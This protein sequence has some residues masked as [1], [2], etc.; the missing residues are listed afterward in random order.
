VNGP[1]P[2]SV[3]FLNHTMS[4]GGGQR[5]VV[6]QVRAVAAW[7]VPVDVW[8]MH[9]EGVE[10]LAPTLVAANPR[11]REVRVL[12]GTGAVTRRL[13][14]RRPDV[15]VTCHVPR[16]HRAERRRRLVPLAGRAAVV[17]TVHERYPWHL[18]DEGGECRRTAALW[19]LTHDF[20]AHARE[21]F[22]VGDDRLAIARPLFPDSLLE[23]SETTRAA[24]RALRNG[25]GCGEGAV[26]VGYFG[27]VAP[28]KGLL[29]LAEVV[30]RLVL[31]GRDVHLAIVGRQFPA[32][33]GRVEEFLERVAAVEA[34]DPR[35]RGR[36]HVTGPARSRAPS[37]AAFDVLAL[38]SRTEGLLPL[39]LVEGMSL[40]VPAVTT[41]VGGIGATLRDGIDAAVVEKA[42]DDARDPTPAVVDAF[43]ARLR[44]LVD[45][46][47]LRA[48]LGAAG[49]ERVRALVA[50]NDFH[51]D[52]RAALSRALSLDRG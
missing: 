38:L 22:G 35:L 49:R 32:P 4:Y 1:V 24:A 20:R 29:A 45:D 30:R 28:N 36:F 5:V 8:V 51:G 16:G 11:V 17:E 26:V 25:W 10:D 39:T 31:E 13:L 27:R 33:V 12:R 44:A 52:T 2:R 47:A 14:L 40:G 50:G 37:F 3:A 18:A 41:D 48:R 9:E 23:A 15:L 6:E 19:A 42:P 34:S 21:A 43:A 46:A 7:D